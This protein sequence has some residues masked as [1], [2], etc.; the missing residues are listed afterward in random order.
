ML[1]SLIH[2]FW[3]HSP[4]LTMICGNFRFKRPLTKSN[5]LQLFQQERQLARESIVSN[6]GDL[7]LLLNIDDMYIYR[8]SVLQSQ[9]KMTIFHWVGRSRKIIFSNDIIA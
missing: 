7:D 4:Y 2:L 1:L 3:K 8:S 6:L 9:R 5:N